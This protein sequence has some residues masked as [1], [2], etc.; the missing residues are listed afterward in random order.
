MQKMSKAIKWWDRVNALDFTVLTSRDVESR[1]T[2]RLELILKL[3]IA[4][5][6]KASADEK[7]DNTR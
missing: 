1:L 6:G 5:D 2:L 7:A 3:W 4:F